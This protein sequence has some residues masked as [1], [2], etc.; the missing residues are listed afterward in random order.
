[1]EGIRNKTRR[2]FK[3][4]IGRN[5]FLNNWNAEKEWNE[6]EKTHLSTQLLL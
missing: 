2:Y 1:M 4:A 5:T 3:G 6:I